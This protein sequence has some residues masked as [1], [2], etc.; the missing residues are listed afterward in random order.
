MDILPASECMDSLDPS[1]VPQFPHT[2]LDNSEVCEDVNSEAPVC[3]DCPKLKG[4]SF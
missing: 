2:D 4:I 1:P 3:L